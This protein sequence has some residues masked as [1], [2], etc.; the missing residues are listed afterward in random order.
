MTVF[1]D[2][3]LGKDP[4]FEHA[5]KSLLKDPEFI[6]DPCLNEFGYFQ[7]GMLDSLHIMSL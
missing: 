5:A 6:V 1:S 2:A 7:V 3:S 4:F